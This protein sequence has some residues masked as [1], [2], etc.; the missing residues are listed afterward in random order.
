MEPFV[1]STYVDGDDI[2]IRLVENGTTTVDEAYR[3]VNSTDA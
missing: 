3:T 2:A 1:V